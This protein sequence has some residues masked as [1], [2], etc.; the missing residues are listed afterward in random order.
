LAKIEKNKIRDEAQLSLLIA[1]GW[2][3]SIVWECAV[4]SMMR[5]RSPNLIET[6]SRWLVSGHGFLELDTNA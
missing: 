1:L 5:E 4:R 6:L 2:R 3:V